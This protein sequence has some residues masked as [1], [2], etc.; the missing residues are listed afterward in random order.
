MK[1]T[2][3]AV[4]LLTCFACAQEKAP[5]FTT[6]QKKEIVRFVK[7]NDEIANLPQVKERDKLQ[8]ELSKIVSEV[9]KA[10]K[11]VYSGSVTNAEGTGTEP[12]CV[13]APEPAKKP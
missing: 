9:C 3:V 7:L 13:A 2:L 12:G 5:T 6:E 10:P 11:W 8:A 1:K 4:L